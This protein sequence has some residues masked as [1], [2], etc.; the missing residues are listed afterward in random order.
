MVVKKGVWKH[1]F[2]ENKNG[3]R[4]IVY[5]K[6]IDRC[7]LCAESYIFKKQTYLKPERNLIVIVRTCDKV[8][9]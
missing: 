2:I 3:G 5:E 6:D 7:I 1:L 9:A 4:Y 8:G